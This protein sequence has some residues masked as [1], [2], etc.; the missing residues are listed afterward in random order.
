MK[1]R[2]RPLQKALQKLSRQRAAPEEGSHAPRLRCSVASVHTMHGKH[3]LFSELVAACGMDALY[4]GEYSVSQPNSALNWAQHS[5]VLRQIHHWNERENAAR[6]PYTPCRY[7]FTRT[8][9]RTR[10]NVGVY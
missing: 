3:L 7:L 4:S 5:A 2:E 1:E 9:L 8:T 10:D 6:F